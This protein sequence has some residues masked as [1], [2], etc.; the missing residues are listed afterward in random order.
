MTQLWSGSTEHI[1]LVV[2]LA[3]TIVFTLCYSVHKAW[4]IFQ[5]ARRVRLLK[6]L[7]SSNRFLFDAI[8]GLPRV[9][10]LIVIALGMMCTGTVI[11]YGLQLLLS[12]ATDASADASLLGR[13]RTLVRT[14]LSALDAVLKLSAV[15]NAATALLTTATCVLFISWLQRFVAALSPQRHQLEAVLTGIV[16]SHQQLTSRPNPRPIEA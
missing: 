5:G 13:L 9:T 15:L 3:V 12:P 4:R 7:R 14:G 1:A 16:D 6:P 10:S 2:I 8:R 11:F